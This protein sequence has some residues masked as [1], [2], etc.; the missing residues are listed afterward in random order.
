MRRTER[1]DPPAPIGHATPDVELA[2]AQLALGRPE[3]APEPDPEA[4]APE[5]DG[6]APEPDPEAPAPEL[7]AQA[8]DSEREA[9]DSEL[10]A[11]APDS[12]REAPELY[13]EPPE[14]DEEAPEDDLEELEPDQDPEIAP[15][16]GALAVP[17]ARAPERRANPST[18]VVHF[19]QASWRE[20]QR[21]QWPDRRQVIQ[22][23]GVVIG[24][25][26]VA[27]V[28]LGLADLVATK[29]MNLILK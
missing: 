13:R 3:L 14:L 1:Q 8:P 16:A 4:P 18:R 24:F 17:A 11:Q 26:I 5:L 27:G 25:V 10:D 15:A 2:E 20:L 9:P 19:L 28:Y 12:E 22:A 21:V 7:D 6:E 23:T 29:L